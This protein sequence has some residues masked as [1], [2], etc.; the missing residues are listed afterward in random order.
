LT[1]MQL[2]TNKSDISTHDFLHGKG[3]NAGIVAIQE[4][5]IDFLGNARPPPHHI[6]IYPINHK[7]QY[8]ETPTRSILLV[9]SKIS[10]GSWTQLR[11]NSPDV[12]AIQMTTEIGTIRIF[13]IYNDCGND[14]AI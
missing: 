5:H 7:Q 4:P 2:N 12:T 11:I 3:G 14:E 13:N 1:I 6:T 10:T 9:N 8:K